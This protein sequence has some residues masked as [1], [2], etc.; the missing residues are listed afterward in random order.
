MTLSLQQ[1]QTYTS[2]VNLNQILSKNKK[3]L[4]LCSECPQLLMRTVIVHM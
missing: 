4:Q 3:I 2:V 1:T